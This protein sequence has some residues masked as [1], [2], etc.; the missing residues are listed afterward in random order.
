MGQLWRLTLPR[1][2]SP[3]PSEDSDHNVSCVRAKN[4]A[5]SPV[6]ANNGGNDWDLRL[7]KHFQ[8][9]FNVAA[10]KVL[11]FVRIQFAQGIKQAAPAE[12]LGAQLCTICADSEKLLQQYGNGHI[13]VARRR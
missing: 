10:S 9:D 8:S 6:H 7:R 1:F 3:I 2:I 12:N 4:Y 11:L 5:L 13:T